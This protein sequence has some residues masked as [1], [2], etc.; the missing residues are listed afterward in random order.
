MNNAIKNISDEV[1]EQLESL[2]RVAKKQLTSNISNESNK[3]DMSNLKDKKDPVTGKPVPTKK[4][5]TQLNQ[6]VTQ[7]TQTRIKKVREELEKQRLKMGNEQ[8]A[9]GNKG[10]EAGPEVKPEPKLKDD[11]VQRTLRNAKQTGEF[12]GLTGG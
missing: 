9:M 2:G 12:K 5:L 10:K 1:G 11:A 6:Q 4:I 8:S 7:L 3:S